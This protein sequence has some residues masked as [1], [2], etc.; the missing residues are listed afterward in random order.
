MNSKVY[1]TREITPEKVVELYHALGVQLP[2]KVAVKV[3]SGEKGNQNFLR[4]EFW[5]PMVEEVHGTWSAI[6]PT[7]TPLPACVTTLRHTA[8]S[9]RSTA[10]PNILMW[11]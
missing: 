9:W 6:P 2:G 11:T 7:A 8:S 10:G 4:P 1:F 3:H 5:R